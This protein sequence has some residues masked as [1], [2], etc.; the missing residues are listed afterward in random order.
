M[1]KYTHTSVFVHVSFKESVLLVHFF[2]TIKIIKR[3]PNLL[4]SSIIL[5]LISQKS[6]FQGNISVLLEMSLFSKNNLLHGFL[7]ADKIAGQINFHEHNK[8]ICL[9][10]L[11]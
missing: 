11:S 6:D 7:S 9:T 5:G 10:S 4:N 8:E 2:S 3:Q 1:C